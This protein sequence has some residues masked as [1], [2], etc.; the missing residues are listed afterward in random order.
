MA[1]AIPGCSSFQ[2][3][4]EGR[5]YSPFLIAISIDDNRVGPGHARKFARR[6]MD[7]GAPACFYGDGEGGLWCRRCIAQS[8]THGAKGELLDRY[9]NGEVVVG[10]G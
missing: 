10:I 3:V 8:G 9:A 1:E 4:R 6:L 7:V 2:N 5:K